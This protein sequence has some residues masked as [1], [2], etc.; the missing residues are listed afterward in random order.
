MYVITNF[1]KLWDRFC[2]CMFCIASKI[3]HEIQILR[4]VICYFKEKNTK[5][6]EKGNFNFNFNNKLFNSYLSHLKLIMG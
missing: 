3:L 6:N 1:I 2:K 5:Q 4:D